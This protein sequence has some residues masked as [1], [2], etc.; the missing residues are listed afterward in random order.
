MLGLEGTDLVFTDDFVF[1]V[2]LWARPRGP[3]AEP[4]AILKEALLDDF[5][6]SF[7]NL[8]NRLFRTMT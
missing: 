7:N 4:S 6:V 3:T 5:A 8:V 2:Q 1:C